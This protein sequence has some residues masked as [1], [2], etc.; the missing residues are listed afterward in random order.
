[1]NE[2]YEDVGTIFPPEKSPTGDAVLLNFQ[3]RNGEPVHLKVSG[4]IARGLGTRLLLLSAA[5]VGSIFPPE[6]SPMGD[7][8]LLSFQ[9][10]SGEPVRL[11]VSDTIARGLGTQ[12]LRLSAT[13]GDR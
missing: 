6:E 10:R 8:V 7:P 2:A 4:A 12:L 5:A 3:T 9:L 11:R 1:M 13:S